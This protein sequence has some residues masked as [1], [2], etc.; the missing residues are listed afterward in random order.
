MSRFPEFL[1][2]TRARLGLA[3][4]LAAMLGSFALAQATSNPSSLEQAIALLN[5]A[6]LQ[7]RHVRDYECR[8]VKHERVNGTLLPE[9]VMVMKVRTQPFSVYL[10]C[11]SPETDRGMEVCYV[12]GRNQGMMRVHPP[13]IQ[14]V[15]GFWS[16]DT[17]DPRV[18]AKNRHCITEA[19]LGN[20]LESTARYWEMERRINQTLV[21]ICDEELA[22]RQ[23][24]RI[25]TIRPDHTAGAFYGYRCVLWLDKETHLPAGAETYDW[26]RSGSPEGG[27]LLESYRF[28]ELRCNIGLDDDTFNH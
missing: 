8:S 17:H 24:T 20:L 15:L 9:S 28:L 7:F 22:G 11:E 10:R 5:E 1:A 27:E 16:V 4:L 19:G 13:G 18:F 3:I 12:E 23:C 2:P 25:E 14:G 26:P 6:R 21:H